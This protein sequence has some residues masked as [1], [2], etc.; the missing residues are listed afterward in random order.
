MN[1]IAVARAVEENAAPESASELPELGAL[2]QKPWKISLRCFM[3]KNVM[4][5][6]LVTG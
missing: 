1:A 5:Y 6:I 3:M 2:L 4:R